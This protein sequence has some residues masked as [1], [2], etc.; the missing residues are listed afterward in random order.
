LVSLSDTQ[1]ITSLALLI[2]TCFRV[3]CTISAYHYDLVC[4]LVLVS[5]ATHVGSILV[6]HEYF[7]QNLWLGAARCALTVV[8][9]A[10][11]W[12][13]F[14]RRIASHVFPSYTP[15]SIVS[16]NGTL[17]TGL[18][19]PAACFLS[20]RNAPDSGYPKNFTSSP[21]W[22]PWMSNA[23]QTPS[24]TSQTLWNITQ[25]ALNATD[26]NTF[27][28]VN[29][30][31]LV[32][33]RTNI[34]W[35]TFEQFNSDDNLTNVP[36][37]VVFGFVTLCFL[38]TLATSVYLYNSH[39][40]KQTRHQAAFYIRC[41]S[42]LITSI[43]TIY[44]IARL[45]N[46]RNWMSDSKLFGDDKSEEEFDSFGQWMPLILLV[47]PLLAL[48]EQSVGKSDVYASSISLIF[49]LHFSGYRLII[50]GRKKIPFESL[51]PRSKTT[52]SHFKV[53][54]MGTHTEQPTV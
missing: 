5:S 12:I 41:F 33:G 32:P 8:N 50:L 19:L 29:S 49:L 54:L 42:Y 38:L 10:F 9:F 13:L 21:S 45:F 52:N 43:S 24:N 7:G 18:S 3:G 36:D 37:L 11:A 26:D 27:P 2:V 46:L 30:S 17:S 20:H 44:G 31:S 25:T 14:I 23:T 51:R 34:T 1:I 35:P 28:S 39:Q 40:S 22:F 15:N 47:L 16:N 6:L 53:V 48:L 4:S